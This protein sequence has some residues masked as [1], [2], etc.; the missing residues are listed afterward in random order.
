MRDEKRTILIQA[1]TLNQ[2]IR[3]PKI[4]RTLIRG[5]YYVIFLGWD[6]GLKLLL[7]KS[8]RLRKNALENARLL[9]D[10][11]SGANLR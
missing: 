7:E 3:A 4:A 6:R 2:N 5:G 10:L 8:S 9:S 11:I 1:Y